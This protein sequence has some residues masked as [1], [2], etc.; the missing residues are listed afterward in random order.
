MCDIQQRGVLCGR[1]GTWSKQ[2]YCTIVH[3]A[4]VRINDVTATLPVSECFHII[5]A[6]AF[7][8]IIVSALLN[9]LSKYTVFPNSNDPLSIHLLSAAISSA[10][11]EVESS[12]Q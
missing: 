3:C 1:I 6:S 4:R 9:Y 10:N 11:K 8:V 2:H 12:I 7:K 5:I